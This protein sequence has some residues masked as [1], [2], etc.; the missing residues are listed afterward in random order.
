MYGDEDDE[1]SGGHLYGT[2]RPAKSEFPPDWDEE[3][4]ATE[5]QS[6]A[7]HPDNAVDYFGVW[8]A[9]GTRDDV[10]IQ[11]YVREDGSIATGYPTG[12]PGVKQNPPRRGT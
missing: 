10:T 1:T 6:V 7:D 12:G 4:I 8:L 11:A 5:V 3:K 2:G 9:T